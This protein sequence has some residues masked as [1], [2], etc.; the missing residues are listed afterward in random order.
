MLQ[1][2]VLGILS[3]IGIFMLFDRVGIRKALGY[4]IAL[5]IIGGFVLSVAYFGTFSGMVV[6]IVSGIALS[7]MI[8][9]G[10]RW[11]GWKRYNWRT[12][13]WEDHAPTHPLPHIRFKPVLGSFIA[14][15]GILMLLSSS[16]GTVPLLVLA[17]FVYIAS[18][19]AFTR[20][21]S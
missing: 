4:P 13:Q 21:W 10:R 18:T 15:T 12:R 11:L 14:G 7:I 16:V 2:F 20:G 19:L 6:G 9:W 3:A 1:L 5:D 8:T 17:P